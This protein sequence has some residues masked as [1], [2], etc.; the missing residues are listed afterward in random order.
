METIKDK[1]VRASQIYGEQ[2]IIRAGVNAIPFVGGS[3]D[4]LLSSSGQ[5]F[6]TKRIEN[7]I[8]ELQNEISFLQKDKIN[9]KY[10]ESEEGFDLIIKS[11]NSASKTRQQE[12]LK[13][14]AR[15]VAGAITEGKEYDEDEPELFLKITEELSVKELRIAKCLYEYKELKKIKKDVESG[16][17]DTTDA[18][19]LSQTY[20]EFKKEEL[21]S[22]LVRLEKTG[23][24]REL[25]GM[26]LGYMGGQYLINPLFKRFMTYMQTLD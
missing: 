4:I 1:L 5:T 17:K 20:P 21:I 8:Y 13:L 22:I 7:F 18:Y 25:V 15:I 6:V 19:L 9:N 11:F 3:I 10:L 16:N 2:T 26:Y 24:V 12:K 23:L 14:Y